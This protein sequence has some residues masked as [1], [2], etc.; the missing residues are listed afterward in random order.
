MSSPP[1]SSSSPSQA[2]PD[3]DSSTFLDDNV[4][5]HAVRL[6]IALP[7]RRPD[8]ADGKG[9]G[10]DCANANG[11]RGQHA[12]SHCCYHQRH[13]HPRQPRR[14]PSGWPQDQRVHL[15]FHDDWSAT[16]LPLEVHFGAGQLAT[17]FPNDPPHDDGR[18]LALECR[19]V[20]FPS[21]PAP[22]DSWCRALL[23]PWSWMVTA[24]ALYLAAATLIMVGAELYIRLDPTVLRSMPERTRIFPLAREL[25][26]VT[27]TF[28]GNASFPDAAAT[29]ELLSALS[30]SMTTLCFH[31]A[32]LDRRPDIKTLCDEYLTALRSAGNCL[33]QHFSDAADSF[34]GDLAD[35]N[36]LVS[37]LADWDSLPREHAAMTAADDD[38]SEG[39]PSPYNVYTR[40]GTFI[41]AWATYGAAGAVEA[42][43]LEGHLRDLVARQDWILDAFLRVDANSRGRS[44]G[45]R[46]DGRNAHWTHKIPVTVSNL[47]ETLIPRLDALL[48][49]LA[50]HDEAF[51]VAHER[52]TAIDSH[53]AALASAGWVG[54]T[55][56]HAE[57][58]AFPTMASMRIELQ[59]TVDQLRRRRGHDN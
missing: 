41:E 4:K 2:M 47:R 42:R 8:C 20:V 9:N 53:L 29:E 30:H 18:V 57:S 23:R 22:R 36:L 6:T 37:L 49:Q 48:V 33:A 51:V 54:R 13:H 15:C 19:R 58:W 43:R 27:Q 16:K 44:K 59:Q 10:D 39:D 34:G 25:S 14:H 5:H 28:A 35:G 38:G 32:D 11:S 1:S 31:A 7:P 56:G 12:Q 26:L 50:K 21:S 52:L 46:S 17:S 55:L 45:Y 40:L 3:L 24:A